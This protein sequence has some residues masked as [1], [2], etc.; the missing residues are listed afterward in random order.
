MKILIIVFLLALAYALIY[1]GWT[2]KSFLD[3]VNIIG[4]KGKGKGGSTSNG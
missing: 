1:S 2:N 3:T 4:T